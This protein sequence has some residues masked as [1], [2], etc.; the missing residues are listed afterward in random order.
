MT[1]KFHN[2]EEGQNHALL[3]FKPKQ[4]G[5]KSPIVCDYLKNEGWV[6]VM[7]LDFIW[8]KR[9]EEDK[10]GILDNLIGYLSEEIGTPLEAVVQKGCE[11]YFYR[12][13]FPKE[14]LSNQ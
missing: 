9:T 14:L 7:E 12:E 4:I 11:R 3:I 6:K 1:V 10:E 8:S 2:P 13:Y 5:L